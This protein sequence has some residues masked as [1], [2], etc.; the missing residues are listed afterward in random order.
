M[1]TA[2]E[3]FPLHGKQI[4]IIGAGPGG[5]TLARLLQQRG[6]TVKV[7]ERDYGPDA[8]IQ[9]SIVDLHFES[10]LKAIN[11]AGLMPAFRENYMRGADRFRIADKQ[12]TLHW[13]EHESPRPDDFSNEQFRP[14]IDRGV[15]RKILLHSLPEDT[16][17]WDSRLRDITETGKGWNLQF[18]NDSSAAA[19]IV[20]GADGG[21]SRV[22]PCVTGIT[23]RY[24]GI[25]IVQGEIDDPQQS[26]PEM[27]ALIAQANLMVMSD[28]KCINAQPRAD[29][30]ITFYASARFPLE[31]T[32]IHTLDFGNR[33]AVIRFL[34]DLFADWNP[35]FHTL[36]HACPKPIYRPLQYFPADQQWETHSNIT[37]L[38]DAAHLMPPS[39]EGVNT[40]MLDALDL[41]DSLCNPDHGSTQEAIAAYEQ[42][43]L[44]RARILSEESFEGIELMYGENTPQAMI[45]AFLK[46]NR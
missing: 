32:R 22:R 14:E 10:G 38:G 17:V 7:Y 30:G 15:L 3:Q 41:C 46:E 35:V 29:G 2:T 20:I 40:A 43:M 11:A 21:R 24:S 34:E 36:F 45:D 9:G 13:D 19:D 25:T 4:A 23:A 16:V 31:D 27:Y 42:R 1:T 37:L 44:S 39:G 26:C 28:G 6:A 5:L 8:R 12:G 18:D 33:E